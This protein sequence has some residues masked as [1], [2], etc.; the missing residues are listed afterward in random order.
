[1]EF[2]GHISS[3]S[4]NVNRFILTLSDYFSKCIEAV[5]L[6]TKE[7][8]CAAASLMKVHIHIHIISTHVATATIIIL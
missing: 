8:T 1:M 4:Y 6:P 3:I 2:I 7:A 5:L